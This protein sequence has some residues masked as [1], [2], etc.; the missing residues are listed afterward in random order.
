MPRTRRH[1]QPGRPYELIL[2][3]KE[4]LPF[5]PSPL[6]NTLLNGIIARA[7][8]DHKVTLCHYLWMSNHIHIILIAK[9]PVST[10]NFYQ[11][12][13]KKVTDTFKRL[14]GKRRLSLWE[15]DAVLAQILDI[16]KAIDRVAYLYA[17][18]ARANLVGKIDNYPGASS[19]DHFLSEKHESASIPW[20]QLPSIKKLSSL[21]LS[22][23]E[24]MKILAELTSQSEI[25]HKIILQPHA[26]IAA[27]G[28]IGNCKQ[29]IIEKVREKES[30]AEQVR[31]SEKK[32]IPSKDLLINQQ[33]NRPYAP[34]KRQGER[35]IFVLSSIKSLRINYIYSVKEFCRRCSECYKK[36]RLGIASVSWP[37]DAFRP[38]LPPLS[39]TTI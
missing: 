34:K 21:H 7:Q 3:V 8:R 5:R 31:S 16:D 36:A 33:I 37:N 4:G 6:I 32:S 1:I 15:G 27:F 17:N 24:E 10:V 23:K 11:E 18:P 29:T 20:I 12:I 14:L 30:L 19:W 13:Q 26:L 28:N 25:S 35:R 9:C 38:F 22:Q 2:R 39:A